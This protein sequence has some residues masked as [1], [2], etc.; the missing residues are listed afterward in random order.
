[1]GRKYTK[2]PLIEAVC[3]FIFT[4]A[5]AWDPSGPERIYDKVKHAFPREEK[6]VIQELEVT[7]TP[8]GLKQALKS[9]DRWVFLS[10]DGNEFVQ[11]DS[12]LLA[13]NRLKPYLS[14]EAFKPHIELAFRSVMDVLGI[15]DIQRI[16]LR[17]INRIEIPSMS[18][19]LDDYFD[20]RPYTGD[21]LPKEMSAFRLG[22]L[23]AFQEGRDVCKVELANAIAE[24]LETTAFV[25]DIDYFLSEPQVVPPDQALSW[26]AQAHG[27]V[28]SVFES[29]VTDRLR[30]LFGEVLP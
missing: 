11:V 16:G 7:Q 10:E 15:H 29:C 24:R 8:E 19:T 18:V 6:R 1:M 3:E 14:W 17:Y 13:I 5:T 28:E 20:F 2:P 27:Q 12:R 26:A 23:F 30:A 9:S 21:R 4:P 22:S 25:L